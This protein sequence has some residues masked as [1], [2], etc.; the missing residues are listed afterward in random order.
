M[1]TV[2]TP[3]RTVHTSGVVGTRP[4]FLS[5]GL[6]LL[7]HQLVLAA[8]CT[9]GLTHIQ[10]GI[11]SA[12]GDILL[13]EDGCGRGGVGS[14]RVYRSKARLELTLRETIIVAIR[15]ANGPR[16]VCGPERHI[17]SAFLQA[18]RSWVVHSNDDFGFLGVQHGRSLGSQFGLVRPQIVLVVLGRRGDLRAGAGGACHLRHR[19]RG[20]WVEQVGGTVPSVH[21]GGEVVR[22][23]AGRRGEGHL[24]YVLVV[25]FCD[26][27]KAAVLA[28]LEC[29]E[30]F[31]KS[32]IRSFPTARTG[33]LRCII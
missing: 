6:E 11:V 21:L 3:S 9:A 13:G 16:G 8:G 27:L 15:A 28:K 26:S 19:R 31:R 20:R 7:A 10:I 17:R 1:G 33:S 22:G 29:L 18:H 4:S 30:G 2:S 5:P 32:R 23:G 24:G 12:A 25:I 14:L